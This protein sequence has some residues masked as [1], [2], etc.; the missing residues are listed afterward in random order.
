[1]QV[2]KII[3]DPEILPVIISAHITENKNGR[4][5]LKKKKNS[6]LRLYLRLFIQC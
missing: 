2:W 6:L 5:R 4:K 1:M 3:H